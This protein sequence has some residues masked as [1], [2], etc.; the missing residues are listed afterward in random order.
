MFSLGGYSNKNDST[1]FGR[2]LNTD[3]SEYV[4]FIWSMKEKKEPSMPRLAGSIP[5]SIDRKDAS[6]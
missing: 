5:S 6:G 3:I 2:M 1:T 4:A